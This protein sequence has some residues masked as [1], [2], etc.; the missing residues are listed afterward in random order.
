MKVDK[1]VQCVPFLSTHLL[2]LNVLHETISVIL[3]RSIYI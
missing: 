1:A 2:P 3:H